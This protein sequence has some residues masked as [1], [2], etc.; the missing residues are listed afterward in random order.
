MVAAQSAV[1]L[2][3]IGSATSVIQFSR[4]IGTT[5][6]VT[7]FGAIV[8]HGLPGGLRAHGAIAHRLPAGARESLAHA[9]QPAFLLG[10]CLGAVVLAAVWVGLEERP[11]RGSFEEP[12]VAAVAPT[13]ATD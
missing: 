1:P 7:I 12:S 9:V 5:V 3:S 11:L 6:G 2:A 4:A 8:N 10:A 13:P